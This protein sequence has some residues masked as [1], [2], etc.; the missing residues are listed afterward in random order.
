MSAPHSS[1]QSLMA[2]TLRFVLGDQLSRGALRAQAQSV[3][4]GLTYAEEGAW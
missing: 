2:G 1:R 4:D 3:L